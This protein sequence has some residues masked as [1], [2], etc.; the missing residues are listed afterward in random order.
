MKFL[1][2][3]MTLVFAT[4][5]TLC[6]SAKDKASDYS[7]EAK[8]K[9]SFEKDVQ[10][11]IENATAYH[12]LLKTME[13]HPTFVSSKET[14]DSKIITLLATKKQD[15]VVNRGWMYYID[16][17]L[18]EDSKGNAYIHNIGFQDCNRYSV[19][20]FLPK[21]VYIMNEEGKIS[22]KDRVYPSNEI[23]AEVIWKPTKK[24]EEGTK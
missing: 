14:K 10:P 1:S 6:L 3:I 24:A 4:V 7:F 11:Y 19:L 9:V 18:R 17:H 8:D 20:C 15:E 21:S 23:N 5:L 12:F 16:I 13:F 22:S 2:V